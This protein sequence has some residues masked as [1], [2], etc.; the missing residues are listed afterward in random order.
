MVWTF[1][2][3]HD[4]DIPNIYLQCISIIDVVANVY[5]NKRGL[6]TVAQCV[7]LRQELNKNK[8]RK[9]SKYLLYS[10]NEIKFIT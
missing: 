7:M 1:P 5:K 6:Q 3:I 8:R 10:N 9:I 2:Q 4:Y